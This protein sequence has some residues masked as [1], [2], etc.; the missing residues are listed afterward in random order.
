MPSKKATASSTPPG[1]AIPP[2]QPDEVWV[3]VPREALSE[4]TGSTSVDF[5][6]ALVGSTADAMGISDRKSKEALRKT[7]EL[8]MAS[9]QGLKP[10]D[11]AEGMLA[12]QMVASHNAAMDCMRRAALPGQTSQARDMH[13]KHAAKMMSLYERQLA[14]LDKRR[15][16]GQQKITVEHV[17]V[18]AG[19]QAIV[20][21]VTSE[22]ALA[23][24]AC[25]PQPPQQMAALTDETA[26]SEDGENLARTLDAQPDKALARKGA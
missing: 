6:V 19:G 22:A 2:D 11:E 4:V 17:T 3:E 24:P 10:R 15:G 25:T 21:N 20:G 5:G 13:F 26:A 18:Q 9:L 14:A 8:A 12:A 23:P 16:A 7:M 1:S